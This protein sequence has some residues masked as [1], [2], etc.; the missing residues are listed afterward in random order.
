LAVAWV[1]ATVVDVEI[2]QVH[3][4]I[5]KCKNHDTKWECPGVQPGP[6]GWFLRGGTFRQAGLIIHRLVFG[7]LVQ[8]S[9]R[10]NQP[11]AIAYTDLL[12]CV[13]FVT[14]ISKI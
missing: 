7:V 10:K 8:L 14:Y 9:A 11:Q 5:E 3:E 13:N 2:S 12:G 1:F 4:I 6:A